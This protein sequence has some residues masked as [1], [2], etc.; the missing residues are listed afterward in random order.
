MQFTFEM[1]KS[2]FLFILLRLIVIYLRIYS[3]CPIEDKILMK[4]ESVKCE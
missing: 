2:L 4:I 3:S 1:F